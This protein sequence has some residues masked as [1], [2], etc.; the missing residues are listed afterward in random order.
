MCGTDCA[1]FG[2]GDGVGVLLESAR[3]LDPCACAADSGVY[4]QPILGFTSGFIT[5]L[6]ET[7]L[8]QS[9]Y[10]V[11]LWCGRASAAEPGELEACCESSL[12]E[13]ERV[14][15]DR[16][17]RLTTRNQHIVGRGMAKTLLAGHQV[18]P[19]EIEFTVNAHGKPDIAAPLAVKRPFNIAHTEGLVVFAS[20]ERGRIGCDVERLGRSTDIAIAGRYFAAP[21]VDYVMQQHGDEEQRLAFLR[22]WTLKESFIKAVG[23]GLSIPLA[24]F[25]FEDIDSPTPRIRMLCDGLGNADAWRFAC[26]SPAEGYVASVA[27]GDLDVESIGVQ[28]RDFHS[29]LLT[30]TKGA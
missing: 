5:R 15:A 24:D 9:R 7:K 14:F 25:A 28:V 30:S 19:Q 26:L 1:A 12:R 16:F 21:E 27:V 18:S 20:C 2:L 22:I 11:D 10:L 6:C 17:R 3:R 29:R 13:E 4:A 8:T 23:R